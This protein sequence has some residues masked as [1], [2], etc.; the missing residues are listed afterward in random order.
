[1]A[2]NSIN[3]LIIAIHARMEGILAES[4]V[5]NDVFQHNVLRGSAREMFVEE[6]LRPFLPPNIGIGTGEII[7]HGGD[8]SKQLDVVLY[9]KGMIPPFISRNSTVGL[10]PW[11]SVIAVIEVKSTI[12][13]S[14]CDDA[15]LNAH[16]VQTVVRSTER[17]DVYISGVADQEDAES[18]S[19]VPYYIFAFSSDQTG[20][21]KE[22]SR[23]TDR[24]GH[25]THK[26]N[27]SIA[28]QAEL[29]GQFAS[30]GLSAGDM[31]KLKLDL[32]DV[33]KDLEEAKLYSEIS[34]PP[35]H[36][37]Y[38]PHKDSQ[39][40]NMNVRFTAA[41]ERRHA[42]Y[43]CDFEND[44]S[45][46]P[47]LRIFEAAY[48]LQ[49]VL[50]SYEAMSLVRQG[51]TIRRYFEQRQPAWVDP[52]TMTDLAQELGRLFE[53]L[54]KDEVTGSP[55]YPVLYGGIRAMLDAA[56]AFSDYETLL[57]TN[58]ELLVYL[59]RMDPAQQNHIRVLKDTATGKITITRL[60]A[61]S[62]GVPK[63]TGETAFETTIMS[64]PVNL[65][66]EL[67]KLNIRLRMNEIQ[68]KDPDNADYGEN[69]EYVNAV[70]LLI[71]DI[72]LAA[73]AKHAPPLPN[74]STAI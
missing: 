63:S 67:G 73:Q 54:T 36:G 30:P 3:P 32:A 51:Y 39:Y 2:K 50:R 17:K 33:N 5:V 62:K 22:W 23:L 37:I 27:K 4:K 59:L 13:A 19:A 28:R 7:N 20:S 61:K 64:P 47:A 72:L 46:K 26:Y 69:F 71:A 56:L 41:N 14:V 45:A 49:M 10:F 48:F 11:E 43:F 29:K 31:S 53:K 74:G 70:N 12:T 52:E 15:L 60:L 68:D 9:N 16:S 58:D 1:M 34:S 65:R 57:S 42:Y 21:G 6:F 18:R 25:W 40:R 24:V 55:A 44:P 38:V 8:R 35:V 66:D